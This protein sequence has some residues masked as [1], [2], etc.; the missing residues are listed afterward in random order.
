MSDKL[1]HNSILSEFNVRNRMKDFSTAI[2][3]STTNTELLLTEDPWDISRNQFGGNQED[4]E[5]MGNFCEY[6]EFLKM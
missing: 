4:K 3:K 6:L 1:D 5:K 2:W